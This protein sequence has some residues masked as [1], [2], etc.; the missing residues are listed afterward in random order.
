MLLLELRAE[1]SFDR[2]ILLQCL[3]CSLQFLCCSLQR[4]L[5]S[6]PLTRA[7]PP[8]GALALALSCSL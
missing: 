1:E 3:C 2:L 5:S 8:R 7:P 4:Q 6:A